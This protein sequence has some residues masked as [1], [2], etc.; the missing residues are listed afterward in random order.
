M[1][2]IRPALLWF[3]AFLQDKHGGI[4]RTFSLQAFSNAG[5]QIDMILEASP[6]A[7][8]GY[9]QINGRIVSYFISPLADHDE[10]RFGVERGKSDGQQIWEA[11]C[12]LVALRAWAQHSSGVSSGEI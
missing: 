2:E 1:K 12:L 5:D 7:L 3:I 9:L 4:S 8:G 6:F 10:Q 11:L